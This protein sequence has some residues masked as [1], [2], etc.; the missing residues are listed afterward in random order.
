MMMLPEENHD[1]MIRTE[2]FSEANKKMISTFDESLFHMKSGLSNDSDDLTIRKIS[3]DQHR[4]RHSVGSGEETSP[5]SEADTTDGRCSLYGGS[6]EECSDASGFLD[7]QI[8]KLK[9]GSAPVLISKKAGKSDIPTVQSS[10]RRKMVVHFDA[11]KSKLALLQEF[12]DKLTGEVDLVGDKFRAVC[13]TPH[14]RKMIRICGIAFPLEYVLA[15]SSYNCSWTS[16]DSGNIKMPASISW[17]M[18]RGLPYW[19]HAC[20]WQMG[21]LYLYTSTTLASKRAAKMK[22]EDEEDQ[23]MLVSTESEPEKEP[24]KEGDEQQKKEIKNERL[25]KML[26]FVFSLIQRTMRNEKDPLKPTRRLMIVMIFL[27]WMA[28]IGLPLDQNG[29]WGDVGHYLCAASYFSLH[30][31]L[32]RL[33]NY[34]VRVQKGTFASAIL[35]GLSLGALALSKAIILKNENY[36]ISYTASIVLKEVESSFLVKN[37]PYAPNSVQVHEAASWAIAL[38]ENLFIILFGLGWQ[39]GELRLMRKKKN[40]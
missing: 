16:P 18:R 17:S 36:P 14:L 8:E 38:S 15:V 23:E 20:G 19:I 4:R 11:R 27:G 2:K 39:G 28:C 12:F 24:E 10:K 7:D 26:A 34:S 35:L 31:P 22:V 32:M 5:S 6:E 9:S 33:F 3:D 21:M 40:L 30:F 37:F 13:D 29:M 25:S 1:D